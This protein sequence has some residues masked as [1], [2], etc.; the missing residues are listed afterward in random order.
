MPSPPIERS[1]LGYETPKIGGCILVETNLQKV[2]YAEKSQRE[3]C[4]AHFR[5]SLGNFIGR[6]EVVRIDWAVGEG[7]LRKEY[8]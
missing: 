4:F 3:I 2:D 1:L 7:Y 5:D 6:G 8:I